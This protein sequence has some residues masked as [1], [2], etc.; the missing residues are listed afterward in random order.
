LQIRFGQVK[1]GEGDKKK[2][3]V[4][5][6]AGQFQFKRLPFGLANSPGSFKRLMDLF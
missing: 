1:L 2:T 3:A 6:P 5:T 4:L